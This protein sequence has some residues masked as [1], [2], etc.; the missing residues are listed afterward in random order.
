MQNI[1]GDLYQFTSYAEPIDLTFHQYLLNINEPVLVHTGNTKQAKQLLTQLKK[2]LEGNPL[3]YIFISHF[4]S[5]ECGGLLTILREFPEAIPVSSRVTAN[6]LEGFGITSNVL[7]KN[8]GDSMPIGD[9]NFKFINYPSEMHLWDGLLFY[10]SKR[11]ILFS[12]DLMIRFG[13]ANNRVLETTLKNELT[14]ITKT[15]IPDEEKRQSLVKEL[16]ELD[17]SFIA[18][19]HGECIR[20]A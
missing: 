17:V 14:R 3:K 4:E 5:D 12:S 19:G 15:Q 8:P 1:Y 7:V 11:Q 9:S 18:T 16:G 6:Q 13:K 2:V 20:I 10:E